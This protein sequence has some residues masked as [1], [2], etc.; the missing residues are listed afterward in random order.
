[1]KVC[2]VWLNVCCQVALLGQQLPSTSAVLEQ[3]QESEAKP[4][5]DANYAVRSSFWD[6][7][8]RYRKPTASPL[9]LS[10]AERARSLIRDGAI[11]TRLKPTR[12]RRS[13]WK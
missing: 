6:F 12:M 5:Q 11:T 8:A 3:V 9:R 1:M 2:L 13:T 4:K 10:P 7:L